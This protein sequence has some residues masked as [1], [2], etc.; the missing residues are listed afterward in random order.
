M[1]GRS[2]SALLVAG[3]LAVGAGCRSIPRPVLYE[4]DKVKDVGWGQ[5]NADVDACMRA[6][7]ETVS[8]DRGKKV[9]RSAVRAGAVG[10]AS[11][12]AAGAFSSSETA[13]SGARAGGAGAAAGAAAATAVDTRGLSSTQRAYVE[14]CL[15]EQGYKIIGWQ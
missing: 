2:L 13:G 14:E 3:V 11:G 10:A 15:R 5:A 12:A 4:N 6:A 9:V 1:N 7:K 8:S